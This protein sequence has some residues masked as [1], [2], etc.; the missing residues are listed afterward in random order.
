M[1]NWHSFN[2]TLIGSYME[3]MDKI[4]DTKNIELR[5]RSYVDDNKLTFSFPP[6][7]KLHEMRETV[8]KGLMTWN[9]LLR[10]TGGELSIEKCFF[11]TTTHRIDS[12]G[13]IY[14]DKE[15]HDKTLE[16]KLQ[17]TTERVQCVPSAKGNRLL[18]VRMSAVGN[19]NDEYD[20]RLS[21]QMR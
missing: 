19:F 16:V 11:S 10:L 20:Y 21:H 4:I 7:T 3:L 2:E 8:K 17:S 15:G 6:Q 5:I 13:N 12:W 18:G 9:E 1:M 14:L